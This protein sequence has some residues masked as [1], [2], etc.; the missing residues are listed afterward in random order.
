MQTKG[1]AMLRHEWA[2]ST[3][4]IPRSH[5]KPAWNNACVVFRRVSGVPEAQ[6]PLKGGNALVTPLVLRVSMGGGNRL[7]WVIRLLVFHR[8]LIKK[9]NKTN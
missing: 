9:S 4:V 6:T 7:P 3:G 2:G 1:R 5:R 8:Y